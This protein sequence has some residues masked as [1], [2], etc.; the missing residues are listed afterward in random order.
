MRV[1]HIKVLVTTGCIK[2]KVLIITM[3]VVLYFK[4]TVSENRAMV[5]P[6]GIGQ[7]DS[8]TLRVELIL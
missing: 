7:V 6:G 5:G 2:G 1:T 8:L 3:S 4:A